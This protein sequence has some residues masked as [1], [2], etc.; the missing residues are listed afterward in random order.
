MR[1]LALVS[2]LL[3]TPVLAAP[4]CTILRDGHGHIAR[5]AAAKNQF[6]RGHPCPAN[7]HR[8]GAC[9]GYVI[10]HI[11]PLCACGKDAAE[12]M[13]WQN[14]AASRAKDILERRMCAL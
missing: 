3:C 11:Q 10:D 14:L 1:T 8:S 12:N 2:V 7:G 5:S 13:Q 9:P 4:H 6:K